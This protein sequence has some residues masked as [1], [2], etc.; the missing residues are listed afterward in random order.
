MTRG[1]GNVIHWPPA[2]TALRLVWPE[3]PARWRDV[4]E[5][6]SPAL[7]L[8]ARLTAA[9][10][11]AVPVHSGADR[12]CG[13][14]HR[15]VD[16]AAGGAGVGRVDAQDGRGPGRRRAV[17]RSGG[18]P[19]VDLDRADAGGAWGRRSPRRCC[20]PTSC[21]WVSRRSRRRSAPCSSWASPIP[22]SRR[23]TRVLTTLIGAGVG[24]AFCVDLPAGPADARR[25]DS[26]SCWSPTRRRRRSRPP[27]EAARRTV[28][29]TRAQVESWLD[30]VRRADVGSS[31]RRA[32]LASL[33]DSRRLNPRA[34]GTAD[35][36]PVLGTGWTPS[37]TACGPPGRCSWWWRRDPG[38]RA[39]RRSVR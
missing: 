26:R 13:R 19:V 23:E 27:A 8:V 15:R 17:R 6:C 11:V 28:P 33:K 38:R 21:G 3:R 20:W 37:N 9:A 29:S 18:H 2:P 22:T 34:L 4:P 35:V 16:G 12:R 14:S 32:S 36:E 1:S 7:V 30:R 10:V 5:R 31:N 39:S 25:P 24:V